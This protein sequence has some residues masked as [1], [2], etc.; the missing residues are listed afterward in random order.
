[1][2]EP[3]KPRPKED[4]PDAALQAKVTELE[5]EVA[6]LKKQLAEAEKPKPAPK[7]K[8]QGCN[9]KEELDALA[10]KLE[11]EVSYQ[12]RNSPASDDHFRLIVEVE[13]AIAELRRIAAE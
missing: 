7:P 12:R 2:A 13:D 11:E 4:A 10:H 3:A 5:N 1:M 6:T 9:C 8:P